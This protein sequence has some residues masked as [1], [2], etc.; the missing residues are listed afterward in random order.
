MAW[1]GQAR[2]CR[3]CDNNNCVGCYCGN[4]RGTECSPSASHEA[5]EPEEVG[6]RQNGQTY[7]PAMAGGNDPISL[8]KAL[9]ALGVS[10]E[11]KAGEVHEYAE[12][13]VSGPSRNDM[14]KHKK[15]YR[16]GEA[17]PRGRRLASSAVDGVLGAATRHL[18]GDT[19]GSR[20]SPWQTI[21]LIS[22]FA[23]LMAGVLAV[24]YHG[25]RSRSRVTAR[26]SRPK[27]RRGEERR[28]MYATDS[29]GQRKWQ[30][31]I[32]AQARK[33]G[34]AIA[35]LLGWIRSPFGD[36][37]EEASRDVN[38]AAMYIGTAR[39]NSSLGI[40]RVSSQRRVR[41]AKRALSEAMAEDAAEAAS[42]L[43]A[44]EE[45]RAAFMGA[46]R[47]KLTPP[48]AKSW[49]KMLQSK[50]K[51]LQCRLQKPHVQKQ[52]KH[53][54]R[55]WRGSPRT[56]QQELQA[57]RNA[58]VSCDWQKTPNELHPRGQKS[59]RLRPNSAMSKAWR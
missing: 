48:R 59:W 21:C 1:R 14:P 26:D 53:W 3:R 35:L 46:W 4:L 58:G 55:P 47:R 50:Q 17:K 29:A 45:A 5:A 49:T 6:P 9:N 33:K 56:Q 25:R 8:T 43:Q 51:K 15:K 36:E 41:D 32:E 24:G 18:P 39:R 54:T 38:D 16:G 44:V 22:E 12:D 30:K 52:D 57:S 23:A 27:A 13:G 10:A 40:A 2:G 28:T 31:H 42:E 20:L 11:S 37:E 7:V 34:I 19:R